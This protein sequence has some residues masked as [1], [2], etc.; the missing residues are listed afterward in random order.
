[1]DSRLRGNDTTAVTPAQAGVQGVAQIMDSRLRGNDT[2]AVTPAEAGVQVGGKDM[3]SR[4]RGND[5]AAG[6]NASRS[7]DRVY[8]C[9]SDFAQSAGD[10]PRSDG[11]RPRGPHRVG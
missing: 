8:P 5:G 3:D 4:L 10:D 6:W 9:Q 11:G 7:V 1:M 2:A